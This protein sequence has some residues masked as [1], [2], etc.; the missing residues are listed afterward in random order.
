M[1]VISRSENIKETLCLKN[2]DGTTAAQIDVVVDIDTIAADYI[3]KRDILVAAEKS[4]KLA[5][6]S[7]NSEGFKH[8]YG[9]YGSA[10]VDLCEV[11]FGKENT[12]KILEF[13]DNRYVEMLTQVIPF[14]N[15]RF[16]PAIYRAV[17][18]RKKQ[19]KKLHRRR[20]K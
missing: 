6:K 16:T 15:E 12:C 20:F 17:G 13:Y 3:K 14:I 10:I 18:E 4:L 19:L 9:L 7:G 2:K 11:V 1:Y 5:Q 8:A